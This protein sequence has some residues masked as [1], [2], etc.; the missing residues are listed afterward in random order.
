MTNKRNVMIASIILWAT[1]VLM[2]FIFI[3]VAHHQGLSDRVL[4]D[5]SVLL[6]TR[7]SVAEGVK[8]VGQVSAPAVETGGVVIRK[9]FRYRGGRDSAIRFQVRHLLAIRDGRKPCNGLLK[10]LD[11]I[12]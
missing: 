5:R 1:V 2:L 9:F 12:R 8:P 7:S 11:P 6:G 3:L 4:Q 10:L